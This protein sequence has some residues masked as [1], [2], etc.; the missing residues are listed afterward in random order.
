MGLSTENHVFDWRPNYPFF[1]TAKRYWD[2]SSSREDGNTLIFT[3]GTGFHKEQW[4]PTIKHL[5]SLFKTR[6][7]FPIREAWAIDCP[8][9]GEAFPLNEATIFRCGYQ[10]FFSWDEYAKA[11]YWFLTQNQNFPISNHKLIGIGHSMGAV[12]LCLTQTYPNPPK[13]AQLVLCEAMVAP[14]DISVDNPFFRNS[15]AF[16]DFTAKRRDIW[17]SLEEASTTLKSKK[18]FAI[19]DDD[20]FKLYLKHGFTDLPTMTYP[21]QEGVTLKCPK[22]QEVACYNDG[23]SARLVYEFM[24]TLSARLPV[25][26]IW[27]SI[28]DIITSEAKTAFTDTRT[29]RIPASVRRVQGAGHLIVQ[30]V[31]KGLASAI[32]VA[33]TGDAIVPNKL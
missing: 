12:S 13:F 32:F 33:I 5:F 10:V 14:T 4:E 23:F 9:H 22:M 20:V 1:V 30:M 2:P 15:L 7:A 31:P 28:D 8:N 18:A 29:G 27:G 24:P 3:H 17:P 25:H 26:V 11:L 6:S 16:K 21:N 19:W